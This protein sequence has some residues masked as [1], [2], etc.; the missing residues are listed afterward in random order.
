MSDSLLE[1]MYDRQF[2]HRLEYN[3]IYRKK[4]LNPPIS[5]KWGD[6][7]DPQ[8]QASIREAAGYVVEELYEAVNLLKNKPWKQTPRHTD[9]DE[10]YKEVA[11]AWHFWLEFM[12]LSGMTPELI[13]QYYFK[14]AESNDKRRETGY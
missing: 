5:T 4:G 10:F 9:P 1:R 3:E 12:L 2:H 8:V 7:D 6:L 13:E 11:D 14:V